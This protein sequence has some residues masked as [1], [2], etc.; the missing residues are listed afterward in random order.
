M[1]IT[2]LIAVLE[3]ARTEHGDLQVVISSDAEGND[4]SPM[5]PEFAVGEYD[6]G[7]FYDTEEGQKPEAIAFY[8]A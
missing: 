1:T 4:F 5:C 7:S 3:K 2:Q 8:P 6:Y